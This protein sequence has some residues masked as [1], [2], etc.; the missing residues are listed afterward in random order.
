M[1]IPIAIHGF[2]DVCRFVVRELKLTECWNCLG[3]I[4]EILG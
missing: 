2:R 1:A 3:K 4:R